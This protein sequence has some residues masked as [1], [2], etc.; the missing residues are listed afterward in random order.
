MQILAA[1]F[2]D[3]IDFRQVEGPATRIDLGGVQFSFV[4]PDPLPVHLTPHLV[5]LV[6]CAADEPGT[7]ALVVSFTDEAGSEIARNVQPLQ[8][9]PGKFG[10]RL[11]R[12][13]LT[14]EAYGT[15]SAHCR[16]DDGPETVVPLTLLSPA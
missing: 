16:L 8:V 2:I 10:Y 3:T 9:E 5:V 11:V 1:L 14:W 13:E 12:A 7:A 6:S 4:S 15:V